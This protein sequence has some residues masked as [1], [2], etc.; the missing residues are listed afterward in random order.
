[1]CQPLWSPREW[2]EV[3]CNQPSGD[4]LKMFPSLARGT[5][6]SLDVFIREEFQ[7][8]LSFQGQQSLGHHVAQKCWRVPLTSLLR[9]VT[10]STPL[11]PQSPLLA[12]SFMMYFV[13]ALRSHYIQP[14]IRPTLTLSPT[15]TCPSSLH[16]SCDKG[17]AGPPPSWGPLLLLPSQS[18]LLQ[19][20]FFFQKCPLV[21]SPSNASPLLLHTLFLLLLFL[22]IVLPNPAEE[23][24]AHMLFQFLPSFQSSTHSKLAP[25]LVIPSRL[26]LSPAPIPLSHSRPLSWT[27]TTSQH[28]YLDILWIRWQY[29]SR[30]SG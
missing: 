22:L 23:S 13:G 10:V 9:M 29:I 24:C 16:P 8:L 3:I 5:A 7:R 20:I 12:N 25:F 2:R 26:F 17:E 18:F 6:I 30:W 21:S 19:S 4:K 28:L 14:L 11:C 15:C 27:L 1:M